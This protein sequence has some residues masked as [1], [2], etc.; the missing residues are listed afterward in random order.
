[1]SLYSASRSPTPYLLRS[2]NLKGFFSFE[3]P[4]L[5][6]QTVML[7][8][9]SYFFANIFQQHRKLKAGSWCSKIRNREEKKSIFKTR[10][11]NDFNFYDRSILNW[12]SKL[13]KPGS[14]F[15]LNFFV[16]GWSTLKWLKTWVDLTS[17]QQI[18]STNFFN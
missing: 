12:K 1:M 16:F 3:I 14:H 6:A 5:V 10:S 9:N 15:N 8:K 11:F 7:V 4:F 13:N 17:S 18:L 2:R